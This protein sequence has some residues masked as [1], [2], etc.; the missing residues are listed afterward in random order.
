MLGKIGRGYYIRFVCPHIYYY[1]SN[2]VKYWP[3]GVG[4]MLP[5][6]SPT[7]TLEG[8]DRDV[9]VIARREHFVS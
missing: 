7:V 6:S 1:P 5:H 8:W 4:E 2:L 3:D 9:L